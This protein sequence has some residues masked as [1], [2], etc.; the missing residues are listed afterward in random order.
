MEIDWEKTQSLPC[1]DFGLVLCTSNICALVENIENKW[2]H[3]HKD[4]TVY[5][6]EDQNRPYTQE[7]SLLLSNETP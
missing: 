7:G 6:A 3:V 1:F 5:R 2:P 4:Q